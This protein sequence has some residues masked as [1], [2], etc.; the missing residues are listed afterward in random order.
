MHSALAEDALQV[1]VDRRSVPAKNP[2][3]TGHR[4]PLFPLVARRTRGIGL[5]SCW[6]IFSVSRRTFIVV[7]NLASGLGTMNSKT[8]HLSGN[9]ARR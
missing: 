5:Y 3:N 7:E 9:P 1:G 6:L 8:R 4:L 2:M